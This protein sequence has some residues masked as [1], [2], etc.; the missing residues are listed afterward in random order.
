MKHRIDSEYASE[1]FHNSCVMRPDQ[2]RISWVLV[3]LAVVSV[4]VAGCASDSSSSGT[5]WGSGS[6][7]SNGN[8][9]GSLRAT[10]LA[11]GKWQTLSF[12]QWCN[13]D[14]EKGMLGLSECVLH[15]M[16]KEEVCFEPPC[17]P[18]YNFSD[19]KCMSI[20]M[21]VYKDN[22]LQECINDTC[23]WQHAICT[24]STAACGQ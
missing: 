1:N 5:S 19:A 20:C 17:E 14:E 22:S 12:K 11:T 4:A 7:S 2:Q 9:C 16:W 13:E 23:M 6:S 8:S 15:H 21:G 10:C 18:K 24:R 3:C